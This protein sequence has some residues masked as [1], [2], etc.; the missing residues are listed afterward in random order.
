MNFE[1]KFLIISGMLFATI[2]VIIVWLL[3]IG[4]YLLVSGVTYSVILLLISYLQLL[5]SKIV[6]NSFI[7]AKTC[8]ERFRTAAQV[9]EA[10]LVEE[11]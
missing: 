7:Q 9:L 8:Y 1:N 11:A 2:L 6:Y 10:E 5:N 3:I 4:Q